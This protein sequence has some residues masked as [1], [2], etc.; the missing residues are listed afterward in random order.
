MGPN[1]QGKTNLLEGLGMVSALRSFRTTDGRSLAAWGRGGYALEWTLEHE[2]RGRTEVALTVERGQRV[3]EVDGERL[4]RYGDYVGE[5]PTAVFT[6]QDVQLLRGSPAGRRRLLDLVLASVDGGYLEDLR[7]YHRGVDGRNRLLK[8]GAQER[9]LAAFEAALAE[10]AARLV[11]ARRQG[12]ASWAEDL[13]VAY[14][15]FA[16]ASEEPALDYRPDI[17]AVDAQSWLE[18]WERSR[19]RDRLAGL[20][21]LGPHRDDFSLRLGGRDAREFASEGQQRSLVLALRLAQAAFLHRKTGV[22]PVILADDI[23]GELDPGRRQA[24]W[25]ALDGEAQ[26]FASGTVVPEVPAGASWAVWSVREGRLD[27][28]DAPGRD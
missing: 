14:A 9:E 11:E 3:L 12:L 18:R 4:T 13:V 24:F 28:A 10:P 20:T 1:G 25:N 27:Q 17:D 26:V 23:L 16:P 22:R 8:A 19:A 7:R 2:R 6:A 5:F 21:Q 15:A